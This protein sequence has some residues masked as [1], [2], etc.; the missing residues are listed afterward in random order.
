MHGLFITCLKMKA[1]QTATQ[2][3]DK[4]IVDTSEF[5]FIS[6]NMGSELYGTVHNLNMVFINNQ[7]LKWCRTDAEFL[8][9][10]IHEMVETIIIALGANFLAESDSNLI[11]YHNLSECL[12]NVSHFMTC[13]SLGEYLYL[14][15]NQ[16][17]S[18]Y[19]CFDKNAK[20]E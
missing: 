5:N 1:T 4:L 3:K 20:V 12:R 18:K 14:I 15:H 7:I 16:P 13:E 8:G 2:D 6:L 11:K 9:T 17:F 10:C 19:I